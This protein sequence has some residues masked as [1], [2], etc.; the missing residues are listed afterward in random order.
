MKRIFQRRVRSPSASS[1]SE[2]PTH[3]HAQTSLLSP[4][5][6]ASASVKGSAA[7]IGP[8]LTE[9]RAAA[10]AV[11]GDALHAQVEV[12]ATATQAQEQRQALSYLHKALVADFQASE[13][14]EKLLSAR[15]TNTLVSVGSQRLRSCFSR[16][17]ELFNAGRLDGNAN[18]KFLLATE[19]GER[20]HVLQLL[21]V[22]R[23]LLVR[24]D[25]AQALLLVSARI[26]STL[27]KVV[28][29]LSDAEKEDG[30]DELV[31]VILDV[32]AVL[33]T[34]P[35]AVQELNESS[36]LHRIFH[37]AFRDETLQLNVVKVRI[38]TVDNLA[39]LRTQTL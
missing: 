5:R 31:Q 2:S 9:N 35:D 25:N 19:S 26:P 27:V 3:A 4:R 7:R 21:Q 11:G 30:V 14:A 34:S 29:A 17:L 38:A 20:G 6:A 24:G 12:F 28:K 15:D 22:L 1:S 18:A 39:E 37:L 10:V 8:E 16:A 36:T 32:L 23:V 13:G 33:V